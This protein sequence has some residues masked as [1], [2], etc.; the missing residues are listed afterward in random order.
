MA[1]PRSLTI[2]KYRI[3]HALK[4]VLIVNRLS[5]KHVLLALG[6]NVWPL[7][8]R[9]RALGL[10]IR[11]PWQYQNLTFNDYIRVA[12]TDQD[13]TVILKLQD[14]SLYQ[15]HKAE[16][17]DYGRRR[18]YAVRECLI[19]FRILESMYHLERD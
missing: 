12:G 6:V 13:K 17:Y 4:L 8:S 19:F 11:D 5:F 1:P 18:I 14:A 15:S 10:R 2:L 9:N 3:L 16:C 7:T